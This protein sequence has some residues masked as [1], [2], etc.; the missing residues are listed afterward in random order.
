MY[1]T[2]TSDDRVS[3][4]VPS[5]FCVIVDQAFVTLWYLGF[6]ELEDI[7]DDTLKE[8]CDEI[9]IKTNSFLAIVFDKTSP[10]VGH[11]FFLVSTIS[12]HLVF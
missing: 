8:L 10:D 12:A 4:E 2:D 3:C 1:R 5:F 11:S 7:Q 6:T 9:E